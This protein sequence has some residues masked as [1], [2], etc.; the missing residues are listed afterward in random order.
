[1]SPDLF[2]PWRP[3]SGQRARATGDGEDSGVFDGA[4]ALLAAGVNL[5]SFRCA[6]RRVY[7]SA[8]ALFEI[9]VMNEQV[10]GLAGAELPWHR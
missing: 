7:P 9:I 3:R 4:R 5:Q 2:K 6:Y 8:I 10:R 1:M